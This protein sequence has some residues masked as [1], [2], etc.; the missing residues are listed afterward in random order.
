MTWAGAPWPSKA[1]PPIRACDVTPNIPL[2]GIDPCLKDLLAVWRCRH[3]RPYRFY[4]RSVDEHFVGDADAAKYDPIPIEDIA[5]M[6]YPLSG[7]NGRSLRGL[8][9]AYLKGGKCVMNGGICSPGS[10]PPSV[11][12]FLAGAVTGTVVHAVT[13]SVSY[14][15]GAGGTL[16]SVVRFG[17][18][19]LSPAASS[20]LPTP[21]HGPASAPPTEA[22]SW[23]VVLVTITQP[24]NTMRLNWQF[25]AAGEGFLRVY[26]DGILV[27]E[28]DQRHVALASLTN[29][30]IYIGGEAGMLPAATHR[31]VFRLDGYGA[32]PSAVELTG[33][34]LGLTTNASP[35]N[36]IGAASRKIH[37]AAG[38]FDQPLSP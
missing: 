7:E 21:S 10:L 24:V 9:I 22:P 2:L 37:G 13:G 26:V 36:L 33:V 16:F 20:S 6:G 15:Q 29:E 32:N 1:R 23:M 5:V 30:E 25:A 17:S 12:S 34:D 35:P 8:N 11:W 31:I 18:G 3:D 19:L 38:T 28:I 14:V 4:G 27:R